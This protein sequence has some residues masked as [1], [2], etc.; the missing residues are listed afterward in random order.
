V[1]RRTGFLVGG[2]VVCLLLAAVVS[3]FASGSL[4]GLEHA[5]QHGCTVGP[6]GEIVGG[7]CVAQGE[8]EHDLADGLFADYRVRG[9][10]EPLAT[11]LSGVVGVLVTFAVGS[12]LFWLFRR[13]R[14]AA[15]TRE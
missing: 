1:R 2:L 5:A 15:P 12:G 3:S 11:G 7:S 4:D 9:L 6:D 14:P 13:R 10:A 8:R